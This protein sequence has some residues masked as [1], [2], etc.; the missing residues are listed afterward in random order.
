[1]LIEELER[2][3]GFRPPLLTTPRTCAMSTRTVMRTTTTRL[4]RRI[5]RPSDLFS[6]GRSKGESP[7]IRTILIKEQITFGNIPVN[8]HLNEFRRSPF[9]QVHSDSNCVL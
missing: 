7:E 8:K 6:V 5:A 3:G 2:T 1:M 4:M 9:R